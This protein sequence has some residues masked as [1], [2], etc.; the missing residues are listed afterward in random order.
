MRGAPDLAVEVISDSS[1]RQDVI[2]KRRVYERHGVRFY[3]L[4]DP[5]EETVRVLEL[6]DGAYTEPVTLHPGQQLGCPLFPGRT[7]E[8]GTLF[9]HP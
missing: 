5:T 9:A 7:V 2:V 8:V 1:R 4:V 3:W 6:R